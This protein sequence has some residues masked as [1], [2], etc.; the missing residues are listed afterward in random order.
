MRSRVHEYG[1]AAYTVHKGA[2]Y[3]TNFSDQRVYRQAPGEAPV[4][5]TDPGADVGGLSRRRRPASP[6]RRARAGRGQRRSPRFPIACS[7]EGADFYSDPIVSPDGKFL[8]WLQWNHPNMPWDGT[9]LWVGAFNASGLIGVREKI[10][11]GGD[12]SIFQPEW[13]PDG[14]L[15]F[16]SDRTGWW[17]LYRWLGKDVEAIHPDGGGVRQ[18]A[19]DVQHGQL[20]VRVGRRGWRPPT[21]RTAAGSWR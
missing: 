4:A 18:A 2:M 8:A 5:M 10:A 13:A 12:E 20:R 9:E 21:R 15:Y 17:N 1:G 3:F 6:D 19:V 7:C 11:G 16:V 14:A